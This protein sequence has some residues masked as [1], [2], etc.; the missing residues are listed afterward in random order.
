MNKILILPIPKYIQLHCFESKF[1]YFI[2]LS[3][4]KGKIKFCLRKDFCFLFFDKLSFSLILKQKIFDLSRF[5]FFFKY[6]KDLS[7]TVYDLI[8]SYFVRLELYGNGYFFFKYNQLYLI[9]A[10]GYINFVSVNIPANFSAVLDETTEKG[11]FIETFNRFFYGSF[12]K[13][14]FIVKRLNKYTGNGIYRHFV[15]LNKKI[16]KRKNL[17]KTSATSSVKT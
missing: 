2:F 9:L 16:G 12:L 6:F 8:L 10:V 4:I 3:S 1:Y 14:I 5:S 13:K 15:N 7:N 11:I 17:T